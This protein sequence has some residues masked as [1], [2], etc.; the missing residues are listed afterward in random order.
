MARSQIEIGT[1]R[2]KRMT[3]S[4]SKEGLSKVISVLQGSDIALCCSLACVLAN[5]IKSPCSRHTDF[6]EPAFDITRL[7]SDDKFISIWFHLL[8]TCNI[9][10]E[11][12]LLAAYNPGQGGLPLS[13]IIDGF[14]PCMCALPI[15]HVG[16]GVDYPAYHDIILCASLRKALPKRFG[17]IPCFAFWCVLSATPDRSSRCSCVHLATL[18]GVLMQTTRRR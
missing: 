6:L 12:M 5:R 14:C 4:T 2:F 3:Y 13:R 15:L 11:K 1:L 18:H 7:S 8:H 17:T 9:F 10:A 16:S